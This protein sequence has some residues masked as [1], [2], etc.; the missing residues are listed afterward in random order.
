MRILFINNSFPG[1]FEELARHLASRPE[2]TLLFAS[3]Y[4][5]HDF[6]MTG[7]R[8]ILL[9]ASHER[10]VKG[11]DEGIRQ[12]TRAMSAGRDA[13]AAFRQIRESGFVPDMVLF[14]AGC[15]ESLFLKDVFPVSF[16]V[17][18]LDPGSLAPEEGREEGKTALAF[19]TQGMALLQSHSAFALSGDARTLPAIVRPVVR[20]VPP[21]VNSAF[22]RP[23]CAAAFC[24][25][26]SVFSGETEL[27]LISLKRL[28]ATDSLPSL[29][30]R[31]L[32]ERPACHV[33]LTCVHHTGPLPDTFMELARACPGRVHL[34]GMLGRAEYRDM[35]VAAT[36]RIA[37]DPD[38]RIRD[39]LETLACGTPLVA[40]PAAAAESG[41]LFP[42]KTLLT[43]PDTAEEQLHLLRYVLDSREVREFLR[44]NGQA[45]V[46]AA[47][48]QERVLPRH[49][50]ELLGACQRWKAASGAGLAGAR[51]K[52]PLP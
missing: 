34:R 37:P 48:P 22:F 50:E 6:C 33:L 52:V 27:L 23:E 13:C 44:R 29:L 1:Q 28:S 11:K 45:A 51:S 26:G 18:Y 39:F 43:W 47:H 25:D 35:L 16:R 31:L 49:V 38:N 19:L 21:F 9:K 24:C 46:Q 32:R 30:S 41:A 40:H 8:R 4:G 10:S 42:G 14:S 5:R 17:A 3:R 2:H 20:Q 12:W 7:V 36:V 15:A